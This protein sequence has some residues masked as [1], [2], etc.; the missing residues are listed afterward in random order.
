MKNKIIIGLMISA[1]SFGNVSILMADTITTNVSANQG[2]FM[3]IGF[4]KHFN[5]MAETLSLTDAQQEQAK[6]IMETERTGNEATI[7]QLMNIRKQIKDL[8]I[9]DNFNEN[10]VRTL[11]EQASKLRVELI[12]SHARTQNQI[13]KLLTDEQKQL[14]QKLEPLM[15]GHGGP[16]GGL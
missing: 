5:R 9:S 16:G 6:T 11:A 1:I 12:V 15:R 8:T 10:S 7:Q 3:Q 4:E 13:Y 2:Q 14:A